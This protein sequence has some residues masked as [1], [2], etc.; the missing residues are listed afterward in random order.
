MRVYFGVCGVGLGHVGRCTPVARKLLERGDEVLFS[1]YSDA[2]DYIR[3]EGLPLRE[4]PPIY[5]AVKPDGSVDFRQTTAYP[6]IFS[7]F[8]FLN[9]LR[10]ELQFMKGF[11]PDFVVADSRV[12][13]ILAAK[14]LGIP[15]VTVLNLY[16]VRI[17]R[18]RR[19]LRLA[20]IADGGIL[21]VVGM[22]WNMGEEVLIPDFSPPYTLSAD[23]LGIPPWREKKVRFIGPVIEVK[24]DDLPRRE[25]IREKLGVNQDELL[26]FI[27]ISGPSTEKRHFTS[28]M[29]ELV[30]KFPDNYRI[31]LSLAEPSSIQEPVEKGN[32][33]IYPWLH[34]RFEFLKACDVVVSRAGLGTISQALCYGKPLVLIPTPHHTEQLNNAKRTEAL[35][36]GKTLDQ[37]RLSYEDLAASIRDLS[38]E[39][40]LS[41]AKEAQQEA[42]K[43]DAIGSMVEVIS[44]HRDDALSSY[45][46]SRHP[47]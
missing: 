5:F 10:A 40:F 19:F 47:L 31:A 35:K 8:I 28:M 24:P 30:K 37:R 11:Q 38:D 46:D 45:S 44:N 22:V 39:P 32:V 43:Y 26:V 6:G 27:S 2:C 29:K 1:T 15:L 20:Q 33:T 7:I 41:R 3:A 17:P 23:N 16:R 14:T 18:E 13:S 9:Q 4:A 12:S 42:L 36:L 21:T 34:N 25:E